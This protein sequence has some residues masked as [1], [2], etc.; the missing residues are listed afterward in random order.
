MDASTRI[1]NENQFRF[2][3]G[4]TEKI[5]EAE[6]EFSS[7][8]MLAKND[9]KVNVP[10]AVLKKTKQANKARR[11]ETETDTNCLPFRLQLKCC[12]GVHFR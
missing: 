6:F 8:T 2:N 5:K 12:T 3:E 1:Y 10:V 7:I 11:R 9:D 4:V